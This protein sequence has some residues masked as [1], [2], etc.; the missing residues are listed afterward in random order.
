MYVLI[1]LCSKRPMSGPLPR[2]KQ[3]SKLYSH[4]GVLNMGNWIL[5]NIKRYCDQLT[6][7]YVTGTLNRIQ[8]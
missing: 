2:I 8:I 7:L 4:T 6:L 3:H 5:S 1:G